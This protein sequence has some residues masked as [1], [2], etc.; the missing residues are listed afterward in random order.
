MKCR[1]F[2]GCRTD[3]FSWQRRWVACKKAQ[4]IRRRDLA[5]DYAAVAAVVVVAVATIE[6]KKN[7]GAAWNGFAAAVVVTAYRTRQMGRESATF[8]AAA[9][10]VYESRLQ[11]R[12]CTYSLAVRKELFHRLAHDFRWSPSM[13]F[14]HS[15]PSPISCDDDD[16]RV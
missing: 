5:A 14:R 3:V 1:R 12:H 10:V 13:E 15:A 6:A 2:Y 8:D 9:A 11:R 16:R 4:R 7:C